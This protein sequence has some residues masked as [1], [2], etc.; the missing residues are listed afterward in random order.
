M[1]KKCACVCYLYALVMH[2]CKIVVI[3]MKSLQV[4][5][6]ARHIYVTI[7]Y[8]WELGHRQVKGV[9]DGTSSITHLLLQS[10][11]PPL[12]TTYLPL[13]GRREFIADI[14]DTWVLNIK[15]ILNRAC[16]Y[17]RQDQNNFQPMLVLNTPCI[18]IFESY[19][20]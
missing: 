4:E 15:S 19:F 14:V 11:E 13:V 2:F 16:L 8:Q 20:L 7:T 18:S 5:K 17:F 12:M 9:I 6:D 3:L 10:L 1:S